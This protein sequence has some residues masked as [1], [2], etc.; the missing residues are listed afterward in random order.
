MGSFTEGV[1]RDPGGGR[2]E[3][4]LADR[5]HGV[6]VGVDEV[7]AALPAT[8]MQVDVGLRLRHVNRSGARIFRRPPV[9]GAHVRQVFDGDVA[10][11]I[12]DLVG[13]A[14]ES[15]TVSVE[16]DHGRE[17]VRA[18][19][20]RLDSVPRFLVVFDYVTNWG[21][22]EQALV[23]LIQDKSSFLDS[24]SHKL[25]TPLT[26]VL[27][28]AMLLAD[29]DSGPAV[30]L[31]EAT[32]S[33]MVQDMTDQAWDL[34]GIVEDL[35]TVGRVETGELR[36][37]SVPVNVAANAAQVVESIG[38]QRN[39]VGITGDCTITGV[40]DPARF[41]QIVRN[42]VSN[43][44]THG[45]APVLVEVFGDRD[46]AGLRVRDQGPGV[47]AHLVESIFDQ[48]TTGTSAAAPGRIGIGL[49]ISRELTSL[50]G[51]RLA[52]AREGRE[53]VFQVTIPA[54]ADT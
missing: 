3:E 24:V 30:S 44:L 38:A 21:L 1:I 51:G 43:A 16:F 7:L 50:M 42:L 4:T 36:V 47:D 27:G 22:A 45:S 34:A 41:R 8:I 35:V 13:A 2:E 10:D 26:A 28:Y 19:A 53:T 11:M 46:E 14:Q 29:T 18:T 32:R 31:D 33:S 12:V 40:G 52:Y 6:G 25:R 9:V 48:Y 23:D 5:D 17:R 39:Q 54:A 20:T 49:W 15:G 37:V